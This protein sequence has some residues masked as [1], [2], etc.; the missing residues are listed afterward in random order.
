ME[1]KDLKVIDKV[2]IREQIRRLRQYV[3]DYRHPF[4]NRG[5]EIYGTDKVLEE[6]AD[7]IELFC[8]KFNEKINSN[9]IPCSERLPEERES[10]FA[11]F[12]G[13][14]KWKSAMFEKISDEV[15]VT[16]EY[17]DGTRKVETLRTIDGKWNATC[18]VAKFKVVAWQPLPEEYHG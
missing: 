8:K 4:H 16:V 14:D 7:T 5:V 9:W 1:F 2:D 6:A 15:N 12:K 3:T 10:I 18:R 13:T 17:A 11:K